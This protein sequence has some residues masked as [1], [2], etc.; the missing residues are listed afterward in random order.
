M[1]VQTRGRLLEA[2]KKIFSEKGYYNAQISHIIDEAGVAR[3]TFYLYFKS[4]EDIFR[5]LL[6]EVVR[7]LRRRIK[8][9][10]PSRDPVQ[11]VKEN[12]QRV[13][14]LALEERELA[15]IVLQ[16]NCDPELFSITDRF[17]EEVVQ[18]IK[19]SLDKGI[20]LGLIRPC[21]T[22]VVARGVMGALKEI[23]VG[24]LDKEDVDPSE[25]ADEIVEFGIKGVWSP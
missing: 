20:A 14:E 5:E 19:G 3:G 7:E 16:R 1:S 4:K 8:V 10:D 15:R 11:Q 24:V 12:I 17:F 6:N 13:V 18:L 21:N 2:A 9:V 22:E 23:I 25:I